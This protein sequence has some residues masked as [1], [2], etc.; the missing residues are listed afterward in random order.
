MKL[1]LL[2]A[3]ACLG[4]PFLAT[5]QTAGTVPTPEAFQPFRLVGEWHFT[6]SQTGRRFGGPVL[7]TVD[8]LEA[9]GAMRGTVSYDG[10]QTNDACSTRGLF[11]DEPVPAEITR[12][13]DGYLLSYSIPCARGASPRLRQVQL[14]CGNGLCTRPEVQAWGRGELVLKEER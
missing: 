10:R 11:K 13:A 2:P 7:V 5:A 12:T 3:L 4:L 14:A 6:N 1:R 9:G 8:S